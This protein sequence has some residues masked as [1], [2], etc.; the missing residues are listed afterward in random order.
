MH[1]NKQGLRP[2]EMAA[3][4]ESWKIFLTI[5]SVKGIYL[6]CS[7]NY[8]SGHL[9]KYNI[10]DYKMHHRIFTSPIYYFITMS[11]KS[12]ETLIEQ[13]RIVS[14]FRLWTDFEV[15]LSR[16][17]LISHIVLSFCWFSFAASVNMLQLFSIKKLFQS[18][19]PISA[20]CQKKC[21]HVLVKDM[22]L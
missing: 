3:K 2:L 18:H 21:S 6:H 1:E 10:T 5:F 12:A 16:M 22:K 15:N 19:F 8:G 11:S 17:F 14:F 20:M 9:T 4:F 13:K 7:N